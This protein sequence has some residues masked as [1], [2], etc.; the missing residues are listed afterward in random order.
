MGCIYI[1][2]GI[3]YNEEQ[4][5]EYLAKNLEDFSA[6]ISGEE[7]KTRGINNAANGIRRRLLG[8][9]SYDPDVVTNFQANQEAESLLKEGY[10][11]NKLL[12]RLQSGEPVTLVQQEMLKI[13]NMELDAK[14]AENPTD[15]LLE[16][17]RRLALINDII[18]TD[19]ARVLQARKGMPAPMTT[20]SDFYI[21]KMNKNGVDV[22][23]NTQKEEAKAD[24]EEMVKSEKE[25][26][27]LKEQVNDYAAKELAERE[28]NEAKRS[29]KKR[30]FAAE[31]KK[32]ISDIRQKLKN[33]RQGRSGITAVPLPGVQELIEIAP[34]VA[35][36][37]RILVDENVNKLDDIIDKIYKI[38][39]SEIG[40]VTKKDVRDIIG[41]KYSK[42]RE[43]KSE[44]Q[45]KIDN[46]NREARL[47]TEIEDVKA[48]KPK[49]EKEEIKK[50]QRIADLNKQLIQA[51]KEAGYFDNVRIRQAEKVVSK[52][53]EDLKR[54]IEE[55]DYEIS[56]AEKISSP[57]LEEL[58]AEQKK[59]REEL[60]AQKNKTTVEDATQKR[61][62]L[63]EAELKRVTERRA[64]EK[65]EKG[66]KVEKEISERE[67]ELKNA[68]AVENEK[69]AN[70]K[71]KAR[72]AASDYRKLE[73]ERNRQLQKVSDLKNKLEILSKGQLPETKKTEYKK[74][75]P[76][77]ENL[78]TEIK[79]AEK[80][81]R[82]SIAY[83]KRLKGLELE[84]ERIK[85]RKKKEKVENKRVL[86]EK[87][88]E[89]RE[90]IEAEKLAWQIEESVKR[91]KDD[92][93]RLQDRKEKVINVKEK[94][95]LTDE[96]ANLIDKIKEE[97]KKIA[98]EK[99]PADRLTNAVD[100]INEQIKELEGR[101]K[102]GDFSEKPK[103]LN[104]L[105]DRELRKNNPE[106]FNKYLD[107][108]EKKDELLFK[109]NEKMAKEEMKSKRGFERLAAETGK[110]AE[111]GFN[112]VKALKAG[113]DNSV[114]FIQNGIAV[115]NPM[116]IKATGK[117]FLAQADVVFSETN[118]R[119][120][121]TQIFAN[122]ELMQ[123][124]SLSGLD[125]ID[126]KGFRESISNEQFGGKNWLEKAKVK[127]F[128]KEY[129]ASMLTAPFERIFA[130][131]SN[132]FRLQIF[133]RGAEKLIA[134]GKTLDNNLEDFK[135][136]ASYA[137]NITGRGKLHPFLKRGEPIIS[138]LIWAPGLM[139]SSLN[140][141]ALGDLVSLANPTSY[142]AKGK[143]KGYYR[144]MTPEVRKYAAKETAAGIAMGVLV[145]AAMAL[146]DD[147]EVDYDPTSVTFGQV[148][149]T[150][151][152]WSYNVFGRFTPYIRLIAMRAMEGK[153]IDGK[154][155]KYDARAEG[156]KFFRGKAA[157]VAGVVSDLLFSEDF[158][159]KR[160]TIDD[161]AQIARDLFEPLFIADLRKQMEI[162]GTDAILT[163][164]IP[165]FVGIKVVNEK[166]YDERDLSTLLKNTQDSESM[167]KNLM[168]N[169][170]DKGRYI[171][172][173]E[174]NQFVKER[175]KLIGDYITSI[176]EKGIPVVD[177]TGENV[178]V[179]PIKE[180]TK[181]ELIKEINRIKTLATR[182]IKEK[183][184]GEKPAPENYIKRELKYTRDDLG[185]GN[186]EVLEEEIIYEEEP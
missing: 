18:G 65:V 21:D 168:I 164:G 52:N 55:K 22:L 149:D 139:S 10:D 63:L 133:L 131:F 41:G 173:E 77:I 125:I 15:E 69:W 109:Y 43:T 165:S 9:E 153:K 79:I 27:K 115:L 61:I 182:N 5:K 33:I 24:F 68:I 157:P 83:E 155:I 105:E 160:Y 181:E 101:I 142:G 62:E 72:I 58:R 163:R 88:N 39:K 6:E 40:G 38:L 178:I 145:M 154:P 49:T 75:V 25:V 56:K 176:Y 147:K 46:L 124:V 51:K 70:E 66:T 130:A 140:I 129:K 167:D 82:E 174:F 126:P 7:A 74:D 138:T 119:R 132:E 136:L 135:S 102:E 28:I 36:L 34:D 152:G 78:K 103:K 106:L 95:D 54:R 60:D 53:I 166:M 98:E 114:V 67:I 169:Y 156:Y 47:L 150:K 99:A 108:L 45:L 111:E 64:K 97:K 2:N 81:V 84:L 35:K 91:L 172:K 117:A 161:K 20:I 170:N 96:E 48:G 94:R 37:V 89:I 29:P 50:N 31:K 112:T 1:L 171:N 87:E 8:M 159:G 116:N 158:Q 118:F 141:I 186:P 92:L 32:V 137:N 12:D 3:E 13:L 100:R 93:Q 180:V 4:L 162:D 122:K 177:E 30:D 110:I 57:K 44:L 120:R 11:V 19:A 175:D 144:N 113:I 121:L 184:F 179:K 85:E 127:I 59:L 42:P 185:I 183:L 151:N 80:K 90:K 71:D 107:A 148:R 146:D 73:T 17:Q 76:E 14:I 23:T 16:K 123:M 104:I 128:G 26:E 143:G 134:K 86:T